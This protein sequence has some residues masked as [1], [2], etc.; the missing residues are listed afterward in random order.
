[1]DAQPTILVIDDELSIR[2]SFNLILSGEYRVLQAASGEGALSAV[3]EHK[4]EL[5]FLDI[6]MPGLNGIET[7]KRLKEISPSTEVV[8][9]TAINDV[10]KAAEAVKHGAYDYLIKPFDV[11]K[12]QKLAAD[13]LRRKGL[14]SSTLNVSLSEVPSLIGASDKILNL[15][16]KIES[17]AKTSAWVLIKGESGTEKEW[18]ARLI[19]Q[20]S[21]PKGLF[22]SIDAKGRSYSYLEKKLFGVHGGQTVAG[23]IKKQ[24]IVDSASVLFIDN[25][26]YLPPD[27]QEKLITAPMRLICGTSINLQDGEFK[28]ELLKK[29]SEYQIDLPP[30]RERA[31]DISL[32][33]EHFLKEAKNKYNG[34]VKEIKQPVKDILSA[35]SWP[36]NVLELQAFV[37]RAVITCN[38]ASI[39][40]KD[41]PIN[42]LLSVSHPLPL[43]EQYDEFEKVVIDRLLSENAGDQEK[44]ARILGIHPQVLSSKL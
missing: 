32:L 19:S 35:Y 25:A 22:V 28:K 33:L 10:Q 37:E 15:S 24:G 4:V 6:R 27:I 5:A 43:E 2:E 36:G 14:I 17:A 11:E 18:V 13:I 16:D 20:A 41:L 8:M 3:A 29:L 40:T 44:T 7:L 38:S 12:I 31:S 9:V 42:I 23:L 30:L 39:D 21:G 1:M 34:S 26:E